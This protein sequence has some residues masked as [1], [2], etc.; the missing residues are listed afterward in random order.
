MRTI[1]RCHHQ[2]GA[3]Q[4]LNRPALRT[5]RGWVF[6]DDTSDWALFPEEDFVLAPRYLE[7]MNGLI[8]HVDA[9][10]GIVQAS[11]TGDTV[12]PRVRGEDALCP[13]FHAWAVALRRAHYLERKRNVDAYLEVLSDIPYFRRDHAA[14]GSRLFDFGLHSIGSSQDCVEQA[15]REHLGR[16]AVVTACSYGRHIGVEGEHFTPA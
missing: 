9:E 16:L 8:A 10:P 12:A 1:P 4:P 2:E 15:I 7:V 11:A 13:V 3:A 14:V 6:D 5:R